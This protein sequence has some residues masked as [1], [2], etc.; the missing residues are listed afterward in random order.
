M[1]FVFCRL[2]RLPVLVYVEFRDTKLAQQ[3]LLTIEKIPNFGKC[4]VCM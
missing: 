2:Q 3:M 4:L 1:L